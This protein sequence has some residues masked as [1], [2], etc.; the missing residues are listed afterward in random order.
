MRKQAKQSTI[1]LEIT[2]LKLEIAMLEKNESAIWNKIIGVIVALIV[3]CAT[4]FCSLM[5]V[6]IPTGSTFY[7]KL[8]DRSKSEQRFHT[9]CMAFGYRLIPPHRTGLTNF[10]DLQYN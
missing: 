3:V 10:D 9:S 5:M 2:K 8:L 6:S 7:T 4:L 1:D